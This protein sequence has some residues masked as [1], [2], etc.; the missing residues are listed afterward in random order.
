MEIVKNMERIVIK[1]ILGIFLSSVILI[2]CNSSTEWTFDREI[3]LDDITP[4]GIIYENET[5]WLSDVKN[6]RV[7]NINLRGEI[8]KEHK[9]FQRPMNISKTGSKI[10]VPEYA[11][12]T[13]KVIDIDK[14]KIAILG[15]SETL[16]A[17]GGVDV[18]GNLIA[19]ADFFNHRV[20]LQEG[21]N[22]T[23]IGEEGHEDGK[24]YYP[25]DVELYND[26]IF[27]ADAYNNRV[28][29]F[30]KTGKS[31]KIIGW[32]ENIDVATGIA[33]NNKRVFVTDFEGNRI[34]IYDL[35]GNLLQILTDRFNK[36]TDI[37]VFESTLY[38]ANY[39]GQSVSVFTQ[40]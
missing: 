13:I 32:Q 40:D 25:T 24:L 28:Q 20:I 9:G 17:P 38:V 6:N 29:V 14:D 8:L 23:I 15:F 37:F 2:S 18:E 33:L 21:P 1:L 26:K 34:L 22:T 35:E 4:I 5:L 36:P 31:I 16:D 12:D 3:P 30:D 7:V 19:V 39:K 10:Y 11:T 27:V